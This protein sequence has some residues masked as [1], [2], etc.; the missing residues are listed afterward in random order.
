MLI[1]HDVPS[2]LV[3]RVVLVFVGV[4]AVVQTALASGRSSA[5]SASSVSSTS[6]EAVPLTWTL[7]YA[8]RRKSNSAIKSDCF[9]QMKC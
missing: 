5:D 3:S 4:S 2:M 7:Y 8:E 9:F 1:A 6:E